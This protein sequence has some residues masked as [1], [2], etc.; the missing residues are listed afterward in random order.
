VKL[1]Q[2]VGSRGT[3]KSAAYKA[4][5]KTAFT[6]VHALFVTLFST[7]GVGASSCGYVPAVQCCSCK[8]AYNTCMSGCT[9]WKAG[10]YVD[11]CKSDVSSFFVCFCERARARAAAQRLCSSAGATR[12]RLQPTGRPP[13]LVAT[14]LTRAHAPLPPLPPAFDRQC[15]NRY[16]DC[17]QAN[18]CTSG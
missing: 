15:Y 10:F 16:D 14:H 7:D 9:F 6:A 13:T 2:T 11:G 3:F 5:L 12:G 4:K 1:Y 8:D 17:F 18:S